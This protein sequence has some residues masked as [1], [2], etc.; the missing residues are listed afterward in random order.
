MVARQTVQKVLN[1]LEGAVITSIHGEILFFS[2]V[3]S[4]NVLC[5]LIAFYV[6]S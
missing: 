4:S 6:S 2:H 5:T 1:G 3:R